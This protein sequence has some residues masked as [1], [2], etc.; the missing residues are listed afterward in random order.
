MAKSKFIFYFLVVLF[1]ILIGFR[2]FQLEAGIKSLEAEINVGEAVSFSGKIIKEPEIGEKTTQ[3]TLLNP[4]GYKVLATV[5]RY[6]E[7]DYGDTLR[8]AGKL[9]KPAVFGNFNYPGYLKSKGITFVSYYPETEL[10]SHKT[11]SYWEYFY[12]KILQAKRVFRKS[13]GV[14]P[15]P[16]SE[17]IGAMILGGER[18]I[19]KN[20]QEK[21]NISG[22]RH[23]I[24]VSGSNIVIIS[25]ILMLLFLGLK[26]G[27][28]KAIYLSLLSIFLFISLCAFEISAVRAGIM[29]SLFLVA[30]LFGRRSSGARTIIIA[31]L[32]MLAFNPYLLFHSLGFQLSFLAS[33]GMIYLTPSFNR[34]L[35]FIPDFKFLGLK[36]ILSTTFSAYIF[37]LP[38]LIYNLGQISPVG[39]LSNIL[40]LPVVSWIMITGLIGGLAGLAVPLAG[41]ILLIIPCYLTRYLLFMVDIFSKP[42]MAVVLPKIHWF[43]PLAY[44]I[45]LIL[46]AR[47]VYRWEKSLPYFLR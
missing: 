39:I 33:L 31:A 25:N 30:P 6:P 45:I 43:W 20:L 47:H 3:L 37:T 24:A 18:G 42:W 27:R 7:Y 13:L 28:K 32:A 9:E 40:I 44:Y 1:C 22:V 4:R 10:V 26:A 8:L 16:E 23:V 14:V 29:G 35:R 38:V 19:S 17:I 41:W 15:S 11:S 36:E 2:Y 12:S 34:W 46:A 21:L 5:P